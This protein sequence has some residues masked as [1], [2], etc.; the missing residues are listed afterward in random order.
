MAINEF[1][2]NESE[3]Y[4]PLKGRTYQTY[5]KIITGMDEQFPV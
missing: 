1:E 3:T 5:A 4:I 2:I